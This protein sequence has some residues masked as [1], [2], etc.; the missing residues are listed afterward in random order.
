V[1]PPSPPRVAFVVAAFNAQSTLESAVAS[2]LAQD[3]PRI[4]VV[5]VDDGSAD[6]TR[7]VAE[8]IAA[9]DGRV[10]VLA[11]RNG[12]P[13]AARN[14]GAAAARAPYLC[15]LD[16]DDLVPP[17]KARAQAGLLDSRPGASVAYSA[18]DSSF[19]GDPGRLEPFPLE[20][21]PRALAESLLAG[22]DGAFPLHAALVRRGAFEAV[23]GF[24]EIRP[25]VED[26]DLWT[27]MAAGGAEFAFEAEPRVL[28][29][30]RA[31][32]RSTEGLQVLEGHLPVL[33]WLHDRLPP[34]PPEPR[35]AVRRKARYR[36]VALAGLLAR[37]G[38][39]GRG[40]RLILRSL[41]LARRPG[42]FLEALR[43]LAR[44]AAAG[45]PAPAPP[46]AG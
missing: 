33:E 21:D 30:R 23:G 45:N 20:T 38:R 43:L 27:R 2:A 25:L 4:E 28:Y 17:G 29:R 41:R 26:L 32:S 18:C 39:P 44:P 22:A 11:R 6:G 7:A 5:I 8:R 9:G 13:G 19:E 31:S 36:A 34:D 16:A 14:A 10:A 46:R 24:R 1:T 15:F 40:R 42:E 37:A 12:G 35:E 3:D